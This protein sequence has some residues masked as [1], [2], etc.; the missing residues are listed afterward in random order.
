MAFG[1]IATLHWAACIG[2][3]GVYAPV[4]A[5]RHARQR[6]HVLVRLHDVPGRSDA[7]SIK[8]GDHRSDKR[9]EHGMARRGQPR[10]SRCDALI[11][12]ACGGTSCAASKTV[13][14]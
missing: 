3:G 11:R 5:Q 1:I 9:G 4:E 6:Q 12:G 14:S 8:R 13:A 2:K 7:A 10:A